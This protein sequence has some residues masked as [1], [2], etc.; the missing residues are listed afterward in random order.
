MARP[1]GSSPSTPQLTL[2]SCNQ[3]KNVTTIDQ[4]VTAFH[5]YVS[6]Y[7]EKFSNQTSRLMKYCETVRD[8][9]QKPGNWQYY[10]EQFRYLRQ[11]APDRYPWDQIHWEL[12]LGAVTNFRKPTPQQGNDK[13]A[14][15]GRFRTLK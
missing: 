12:W 5:T 3:P 11:S 14:Q 6:I 7:S 2:E 13:A 4:W 1:S 15:R 10:D 9:V 8:L